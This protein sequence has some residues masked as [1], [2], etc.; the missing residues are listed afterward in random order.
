MAVRCSNGCRFVTGGELQNENHARITD[1]SGRVLTVSVDDVCPRRVKFDG[2][3]NCNRWRFASD[4]FA[5]RQ[6]CGA[7]G[8]NST[9]ES[10]LTW[11]LIVRLS[12]L[13]WHHG[14]TWLNLATLARCMSNMRNIQILH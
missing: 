1:R 8:S 14:K 11:N 9:V 13:S 5:P 2:K 10:W 12:L 3:A 7:S 4:D 6:H